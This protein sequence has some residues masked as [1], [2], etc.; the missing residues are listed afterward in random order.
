MW[1]IVLTAV[2]ASVFASVLSACSLFPRYSDPESIEIDGERYVT[3]F[4]ENLWPDGI[5]FDE[6]D[7]PAFETKYHRWWKE[8]GGA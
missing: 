4:Y 7:A 3:G 8:A 2:T 5:V 1:K 6:S